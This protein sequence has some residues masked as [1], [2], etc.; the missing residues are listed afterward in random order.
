MRIRQR[1]G[2]P[3]RQ[4]ALISPQVHDTDRTMPAPL[5]SVQVLD[6]VRGRPA[7]GLVV[8]LWRLSP[9]T[10]LVAATETDA[11]GRPALAATA[12]ALQ[13]GA[14]ELR[15]FIGD[16]YRGTGLAPE[17]P[18]LDMVPVRLFLDAQAGPSHLLIAVGP[19]S[20]SVRRA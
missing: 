6:S 4:S 12:E 3:A 13:P 17:P 2:L 5:L 1:H 11:E 7:T 18:L 16:F 19:F 9:A 14:H 8:E 15:L 10:I 20:Y